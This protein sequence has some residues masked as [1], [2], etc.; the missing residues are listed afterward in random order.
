MTSYYCSFQ[1]LINLIVGR[2]ESHQVPHG[3]EDVGRDRCF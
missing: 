3:P 2:V 1:Y